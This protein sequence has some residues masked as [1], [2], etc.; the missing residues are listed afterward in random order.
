M[1]NKLGVIQGRL[2]PK[3]KGR[4][5]AFPVGYWKDEFFIAQNLG[6]DLIEFILDFNDADKNPLLKDGGINEINELCIYLKNS[7]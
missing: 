4:Y 2:V 5:Q 7:H 1:N 3:Y 6:L